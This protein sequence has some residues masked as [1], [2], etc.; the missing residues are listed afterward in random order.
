[1][2]DSV[3][4]AAPLVIAAVVMAVRFVGCSFSPGGV[5]QANTHYS[6]AVLNDPHLV[7]FWRLNEQSGTVAVD[8]KGANNGT[9]QGGVTLGVPGLVSPDSQD[10][11]NLAAQFDGQ[12]G[13]VSVQFDA[14]LNPPAFTVEA[15][16]QP[17]GTDPN[18]HVIVSSDTGYQLV[19]NGGAFEASVAAGGAFQPPARATRTGCRFVSACRRSGGRRQTGGRPRAVAAVGR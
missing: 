2:T 19:L 12:T 4:I 6:T 16:V 17:S 7:S 10:S 15:L 8:S 11:D 3:I 9:Y 1:M 13:Y 5:P 14:D 18:K